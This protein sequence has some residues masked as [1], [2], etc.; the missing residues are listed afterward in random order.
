MSTLLCQH[1]KT[2]EEQLK[3]FTKVGIAGP[4]TFCCFF[5]E[6]HLY[7]PKGNTPLKVWLGE[8]ASNV[9]EL[10]PAGLDGS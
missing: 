7:H 6:I 2:L 5:K 3:I 8:H 4:K 10:C 9:V 1:S